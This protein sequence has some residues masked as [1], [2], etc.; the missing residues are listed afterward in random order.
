MQT[1]RPRALTATVAA[2]MLAMSG[3][4]TAQVANGDVGEATADNCP[5]VGSDAP[6]EE[7]A[8]QVLAEMTDEEKFHVISAHRPVVGIDRL[9]LPGIYQQGGPG[10]PN[11]GMSGV[12]QLPT[13]LAL[14]ATFDADLAEQ[15]GDVIGAEVRGKGTSLVG[16]PTL[17]IARNPY[18]G[19]SYEA[20]GEDPFLSG[21]LGAGTVRGIQSNDVISFTK[22]FAFYTQQ[23][24]RSAPLNHDMD[25]RTLREI[26]LSAFERAIRDGGSGAVMCSYSAINGRP[27]CAS[28]EILNGILKDDWGFAGVVGPDWGAQRGG[29]L[30]IDEFVNSG[31]DFEVPSRSSFAQLP[32]LVEEGRVSMDRID[33]MAT[34]ILTSM[35]ANGL[36]D[37]PVTGSQDAVVTTPE[38]QAVGHETAIQSTV[39]LKNDDVLPLGDPSSIAVIGAGAHDYPITTGGSSAGTVAD[40]VVTA[41]DGIRERAGDDVGIEY[42]AGVEPVTPYNALLPGLPNVPQSTLTAPDGALGVGVEHFA[43]DGS[44]ISEETVRSVNFDWVSAFLQ[45]NVIY[46]GEQHTPPS[47]TARSVWTSTFTAP[48]AGEYTFDLHT[49]GSTTVS[50]D[51]EETLRLTPT[52]ARD[53]STPS[54]PD[55]ASDEWSMTLGAGQQIEIR[56]EASLGTSGKIKLGWQPPAGV[57]APAIAEAAAAAAESDV[58]VVVVSDFNVEGT[59]KP[60]LHLPGNQDALVEAVIEANPN[61]VVVLN[62]GGPLVLPWA[63]DAAAILET[64]YAGQSAGDALAAVLWG[65]VDPGGR[66]PITLP[67]SDDATI[68]SDDPSRYPL[69][70]LTVPYTEGHN[71]GYRWYDSAGVEPLFHFGHGLSYADMTVSDVAVTSVPGNDGFFDVAA[72]ITNTSDRAGTAVPQLYVGLP[73][74]ADAAP[75]QLRGFEKIEVAPSDSQTVTFRVDPRDLAYWDQDS[76]AWLAPAGAYEISVG[77]SSA[78]DAVVTAPPVVLDEPIA[79]PG[80]TPTDPDV[81][82]IRVDA[83]TVSASATSDVSVSG[84]IPGVTVELALESRR[85]STADRT[86]I[87]LGEIVA[88]RD[89]SASTTVR[90]PD[91]T[92]GGPYVVVAR[93]SSQEA[94]ERLTINRGKAGSTR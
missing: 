94:S 6:P 34:R 27:V 1:R 92:L 13:P 32:A 62:T 81:A 66:L 83:D 56:V 46:P 53:R 28:D 43:S 30:T 9:C 54:A 85:G 73:D 90:V 4:A 20:Y 51:G 17:D 36:V 89:G 68:I 24:N 3:V 7:R 80:S 47:G 26:H 11:Q 37:N 8:A 21:A 25:E 75:R 23:K 19:R 35:F 12:T 87:P 22:H 42:Y 70:E 64:W 86:A 79:M 63:D 60:H 40:S 10:G 18:S 49:S 55:L 41:L 72:T 78:A 2:A 59:D 58:A 48:Q 77:F 65:D 88:T 76:D 33:D 61:T 44:L 29:G 31:L 93:S 15:Y 71:A 16:A 45:T 39:L 38:H 52:G 57:V 50:V 74:V 5:W 82:S 84:F 91:D 14:G 69:T 67:A